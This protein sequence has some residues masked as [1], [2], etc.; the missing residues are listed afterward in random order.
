MD[1]DAFVAVIREALQAIT[2][3]R[4]FETERG[5]Q[6]AFVGELSRRLPQLG[7]EIGGALVE[8]EYQ[9]RLRDHGLNIRPDLIIHEPFN[10]NRHASRAE[11]NFAVF[12]LK[13]RAA[14]AEAREDFV[15][16]D[17]MMRILSYPVGVFVNIDS[18]ETHLIEAPKHI[19]GRL[20][21]FA[22]S[23]DNK[24]VRIV[25]QAR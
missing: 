17:S 15:N 10:P 6:G 22:V 5:Y 20:I 9:K 25:E 18:I 1:F 14:S 23:L 7:A 11:G 2:V 13:H 21:A 8:Q 4:L 19:H 12:E 3:P 16:L 24:N